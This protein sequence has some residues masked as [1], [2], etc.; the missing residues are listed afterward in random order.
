M[1]KEKARKEKEQVKSLVKE[2]FKY[3]G[4]DVLFEKQFIKYYRDRGMSK[5]EVDRLWVKAHSMKIIRIGSKPVFCEKPYRI[6]G[7]VMV[8]RLLGKEGV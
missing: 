7:N 4:K 3:Y 5:D 2:A 8:F 1:D 6:L